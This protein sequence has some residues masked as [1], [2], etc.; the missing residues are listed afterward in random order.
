MVQLSV[1]KTSLAHQNIVGR[2]FLA[3]EHSAR[4]KIMQLNIVS[5]RSIKKNRFALE[6]MWH[7][8][9]NDH[10]MTY[11]RALRKLLCFE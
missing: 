8:N 2:S 5:T 1:G 4:I 7:Q 3:E 10:E 9:D 11:V 6:K